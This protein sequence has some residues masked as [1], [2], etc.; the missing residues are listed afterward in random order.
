M[1]SFVFLW[2]QRSSNKLTMK[3]IQ[4]Q[5]FIYTSFAMFWL[6]GCRLL[7]PFNS[8]YLGNWTIYTQLPVNICIQNSI[9]LDCIN[10]YGPVEYVRNL[11]IS[12]AN[13]SKLP[14]KVVRILNAENIVV[15]R[16]TV[17]TIIK[18]LRE[19]GG[20]Q[21]EDWWGRPTK[22]T[23]PVKRKIDEVYRNDPKV[24][25]TALEPR[26]VLENKLPDLRIGMSTI[27]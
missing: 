15:V 18:H 11:I 26:N 24:H 22:A 19:K 9:S 12:L 10:M 6:L 17:C 23:S 16:S 3:S 7:N 21:W 25:V 2:C 27:K 8:C 20:R 1:K 4:I 5:R 14:T 13:F